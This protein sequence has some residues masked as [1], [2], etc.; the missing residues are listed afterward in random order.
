MPKNTIIHL[1]TKNQEYLNKSVCNRKTVLHEIFKTV[2]KGSVKQGNNTETFRINCSNRF[3]V[4]S[5]IDDG[6]DDDNDS[7]S[8]KSENTITE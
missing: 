4:L 2:P 8:G 6:D 3:E 1:L 5:T 7:K